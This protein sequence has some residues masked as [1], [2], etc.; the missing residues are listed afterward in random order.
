MPHEF[1]WNIPTN[2]IDEKAFKTVLSQN[3]EFACKFM[4]EQNRN[5]SGTMQ[6]LISLNKKVD[7]F[8]N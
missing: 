2:T 5:A 4:G 7:L 6:K 3:N 1:A 8:L